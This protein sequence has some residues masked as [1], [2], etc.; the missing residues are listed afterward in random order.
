MTQWWIHDKWAVRIGIERDT[1]YYV[2]RL[3]DFGDEV[4]EYIEY[5]TT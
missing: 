4:D 3:I 1:S 5:I 2:N